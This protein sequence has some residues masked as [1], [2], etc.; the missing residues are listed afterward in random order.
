MAFEEEGKGG[1]ALEDQLKHWEGGKK[2][3]QFRTGGKGVNHKIKGGNEGTKEG[4][5]LR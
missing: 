5:Y 4:S 2:G 3:Y 1:R